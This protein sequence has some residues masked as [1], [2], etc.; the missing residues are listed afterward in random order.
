MYVFDIV[1][2]FVAG[3]L[4][5]S[6]LFMLLMAGADSVVRL[7]ADLTLFV[8]GVLMALIAVRFLMLTGV[9]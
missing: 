7:V 8:C 6:L 1:L 4:V 5:A 2:Y 3:L 9:M